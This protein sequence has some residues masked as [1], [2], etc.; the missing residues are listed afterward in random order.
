MKHYMLRLLLYV[1]ILISPQ[2]LFGQKIGFLLDS[3][4]SDRWALD[5]QLFCDRISQLGGEC[6]VEVAYGDPNE[7]LRLA[8]KLI[9]D[10]AKILVVVPVD[11]K[12]AADIVAVA[13]KSGIK[14]V[15]YD[16]LISH[17]DLALYVS[18]NNEKVGMLQARYALSKAPKGNYVLLNGP[19]TDNNAILLRQGQLK[20]LKP[21]IDKGAVQVVADYIMSDWG[22]IGALLQM[23]EFYFS[24][25]T[26]PQVILAA[27]D[28]LASGAIQAL[29]VLNEAKQMVITGQD[30]DLVSIKNIITGL[31]TMTIY[32]PLKPLA[33]LAAEA[34][35]KLMKGESVKE[36]SLMKFESL[37][38]PT[39]LLDPIVVDKANFRDT[40]VKDGHVSLSEMEQAR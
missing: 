15:A 31:Q 11:G 10:G 18:Y 34:T 22:E 27:N 35:F 3:Y 30:A 17:P 36:A 26:K 12:K 24:S 21:S 8:Q 5:R 32:K 16:R 23:D 28:A 4:V 37:S 13:K 2:V 29:P 9:A 25:K 7:Q 6:Q 20:E 33:N 38:V 40:V 1:L 39:V 14:V 19:T